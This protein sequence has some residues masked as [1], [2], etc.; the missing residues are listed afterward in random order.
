ML[1]GCRIAKL[2][3]IKVRPGGFRLNFPPRS[4]TYPAAEDYTESNAHLGR[5]AVTVP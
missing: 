5:V 2:I 3:Q 4:A 1:V